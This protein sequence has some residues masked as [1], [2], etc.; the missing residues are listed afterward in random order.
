MQQNGIKKIELMSK[1][2]SSH[3][4]NDISAFCDMPYTR[5]LHM[6]KLVTKVKNSLIDENILCNY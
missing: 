4:L 2:G 6:E 5:E 1:D 3:V